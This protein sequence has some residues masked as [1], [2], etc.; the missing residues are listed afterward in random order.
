M[1]KYN[2]WWV[3]IK[4]KAM[5][6]PITTELHGNYDEKDVVEFYG[7]NQPDVE[8]YKMEEITDKKE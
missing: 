8:W 6:H 3:T 1:E 5:K 4:E 7:L 2:H